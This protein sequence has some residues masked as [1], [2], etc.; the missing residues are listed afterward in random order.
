[1]GRGHEGLRGIQAEPAARM[2]AATCGTAVPGCRDQTVAHPGY[3]CRPLVFKTHI[4]KSARPA[5]STFGKYSGF[6]LWQV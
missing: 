4:T 1:M 3:A 2:S 5:V 6:H